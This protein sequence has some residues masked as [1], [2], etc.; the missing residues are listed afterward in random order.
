MHHVS[1]HFVFFGTSSFAVAVLLGLMAEGHFPRLIVTT[2]DAPA[3]RNRVLTASVVKNFASLKSIPVIEPA[4]LKD[5][6]SASIERIISTRCD[7]F[8]VA[9]YGKIIPRR[10]LDIPKKGALNVHVSLLPKYRGPSPMQTAILEGAPR[11]GVTIMEM[12][13]RLDEG[14]ILAQEEFDLSLWQPAFE[15]LADRTAK[16]GAKILTEVMPLWLLGRLEPTDQDNQLA[17]YTKMFTTKD[18]FIEGDVVLGRSTGESAER[19]HR[20][21][22]ALSHNP[23]TWTEIPVNKKLL[24]IKILT[25]RMEGERF[26]PE[27]IV[28]AGKKEMSWQSFTMG[29]KIGA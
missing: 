21:V 1:P 22:R 25:A 20:R 9:D 27:K 12:V 19:A 11:T 2:P 28:P 4:S 18:G 29:N 16:V 24:R 10:L 14:P 15:E 23:G 7:L 17:T 26:V 8:I 3:G 13:E 6:D 5:I